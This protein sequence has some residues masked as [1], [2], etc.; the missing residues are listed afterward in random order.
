M[1]E[2]NLHAHHRQRMLVRLERG[3]I[4]QDHELLE[5]FLYSILPRVDTNEMAHRL[6]DTFKDFFGVFH[7]E[8]ES[9]EKRGADCANREG[10]RSDRFI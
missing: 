3:D 9:L 2:E 10:F 4:L 6:L 8:K 7:A 1:G 5:I